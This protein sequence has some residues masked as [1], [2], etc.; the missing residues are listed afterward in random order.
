MWWKDEEDLGAGLVEYGLLA[1]LIAITSL[2]AV[3]FTGL[4]ISSLW[5]QLANSISDTR[6]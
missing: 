6:S 3:R 1:L 5:E 2:L 4:E